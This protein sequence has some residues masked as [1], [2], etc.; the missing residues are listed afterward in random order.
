MFKFLF[1][2]NF[3][4]EELLSKSTDELRSIAHSLGLKIK[5]NDAQQ[6]IAYMIID[7]QAI[8]NSKT[9]GDK[10]KAKRPR[11]G[12]DKAA[13]RDKSKKEDKPQPDKSAAKKEEAAAPEVKTEPKRRGRPRKE[14]ATENKEVNEPEPKAAAVGEQKPEGSKRRGRPRKNAEGKPV[15]LLGSPNRITLPAFSKRRQG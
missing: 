4:L 11:I 15:T 12:E 6:D 8:Q 3:K 7:E 1:M 2:P 13:K 14:E 5:Q 10:P 9:I